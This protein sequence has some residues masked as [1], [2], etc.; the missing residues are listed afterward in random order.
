MLLKRTLLLMLASAMML[1][2]IVARAD[3]RPAWVDRSEKELNAKR[4]NDTYEF[5]VL[6]SEDKELNRLHKG[7]FYPLLEYLAGEYGSK[8]ETM[9]VDS[10]AM[11]GNL[12][13]YRITFETALGRSAVIARLVEVY[14]SIDY[15]VEQDPV[16]ELCQLFAIGRKDT[17]VLFDEFA[18]KEINRPL[19]GLMSVIP[20]TGQ[21]YKGNKAKGYALLGTSLAFAGAAVASQYKMIEWRDMMDKEPGGRDS[22]E[23]KSIAMRKQRNI[24]L[25]AIGC[26]SAYSIFDALVGDEVPRITVRSSGG[27]KI[28]VAPQGAG[29]AF[30]I[31]F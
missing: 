22:W 29:M 19:A 13:T 11:A 1:Q 25:G 27:S 8:P 9:T 17:D 28:S 10:L 16:F 4:T 30:R 7:R 18:R 3:V 15:N 24:L 23:S 14:E 31:E 20:G 12:P 21:L 5:K 2:G 26:L 6:R